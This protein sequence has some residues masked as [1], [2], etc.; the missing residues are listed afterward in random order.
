MIT[1]LDN[2]SWSKE[3]VTGNAQFIEIGDTVYVVSQVRADNTFAVFKSQPTPPTPGPGY[4]F[5]T[6]A[7]YLFPV[8]NTSFDP[9]IAYDPLGQV[10]YIVGTQNN[11]NST[12]DD[13][14]YDVLLFVYDLTTDT[15]GAPTILVTASYVQDSFDVCTLG[16]FPSPPV[17]AN[18][19]IAVAVTNP[20]QIWTTPT[21]SIF[22][23][24][25]SITISGDVM[26]VVVDNGF[27]PEQ[28][29]TFSALQNA[30]FL[31]GV[32]VTVDTA[33]PTQFTATYTAPDYTQ[34][35]YESGYVTWFPGHSL[36]GF[37]LT[38]AWRTPTWDAAITL[39]DSSP[40]RSGNTFGAVSAYSP[41]GYNI[42][43]YY[44]SHPKLVTFTDQL[45]SLVL[46]TR[47]FLT[48]T[49]GTI[50]K[51]FTGRY[52]DSRLT[53]I[54]VGATRLLSQQFY[55][56]LVHQNALV[57]NVLLGYYG[58]DFT[59]SPPTLGWSFNIQSG[60]STS[61]YIQNTLSTSETQGSF[62]SYLAE[63][64][65]SVRGTWSPQVGTYAINDRVSYN[66]NPPLDSGWADYIVNQAITYSYQGVWRAH[67]AYAVGSVVQVALPT[68][69]VMY[70][71]YTAI[72][73]VA[74]QLSPNLDV[75][76][77]EA[78]PTP[79]HDSRFT[80]APTAWQLQTSSLDLSNFNL[81]N[82]PGYY[83]NLNFSW[84][85]GLEGNH[86]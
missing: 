43:V 79:N 68:N 49:L 13:T 42:E 62:L 58:Y 2:Q 3:I 15:L 36:L 50:L 84:I 16:Y 37:E 67:A 14:L 75:V 74:S 34:E 26:T 39:L 7:S 52:A 24:T 19:F 59:F 1:Q 69:P 63:P 81:T 64:V 31:N 54:P 57:G 29:V 61:S 25:S 33:S 41:N 10:L 51:T 55:S 78:T 9:A 20:V 28:T 65:Y 38:P 6:T 72:N 45:F 11:V 44:E 27:S 70:V 47:T 32:T 4:A 35:G 73:A 82:I 53:V 8:T 71:Y 12:N 56:Q 21:T 86:R 46:A 85:R 17:P 18:P 77:W 5:S 60:S 23:A 48:W 66:L 30:T 22:I 40:L 76:N 80:L 83:N